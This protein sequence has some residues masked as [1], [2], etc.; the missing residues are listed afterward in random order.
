MIYFVRHGEGIHNRDKNYENPKYIDAV[1][2]TE[3]RLQADNLR[4]KKELE[5]PDIVISSPLARALETATI[6][7]PDYPILIDPLC[8]EKLMYPCD[9]MRSE[10][11]SDPLK[12]TDEQMIERAELFVKKL[13][14]EKDKKIVVF[15]HGKFMNAVVTV[16][17]G[18]KIINKT[19]FFRN[20]EILKFPNCNTH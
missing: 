2:T 12:E 6:A 16:M 10:V 5:N 7:Y 20:T 9:M 18:E 14:A 17:K 3:G 1:L 8:R 15:T 11:A 19:K 4:T 13:T